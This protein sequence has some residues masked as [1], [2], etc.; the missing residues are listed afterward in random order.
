MTKITPGW[1]Q[2]K[3]FI[4]ERNTLYKCL[5]QRMLKSKSLDKLDALEAK[6]QSSIN[7]SKF[8]YYSKITKI[9]SDPSTSSKCC[10]NLL[11]TLLNGRKSPC[12]SPLFHEN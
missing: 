5:K 3:T 12:I 1:K 8:G 2:I 10:W 7:V 11:K 6:L 9:W 4:V